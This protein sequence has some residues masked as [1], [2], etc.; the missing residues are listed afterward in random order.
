MQTQTSLRRGPLCLTLINTV[1][2]IWCNAFGDEPPLVP[3]NLGIGFCWVARPGWP[4]TLYEASPCLFYETH[5]RDVNGEIP[6]AQLRT[7]RFVTNDAAAAWNSLGEKS[8]LASHTFSNPILFD[9][10]I[11]L[12]ALV[13]TGTDG[14]EVHLDT[15]GIKGC[16]FN[17]ER[18]N[19]QPIDHARQKVSFYVMVERI[20]VNPP[21]VVA[22][23]VFKVQV[24]ARW[25]YELDCIAHISGRTFIV[26]SEEWTEQELDV[27]QWTE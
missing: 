16:T 10:E 4:Y 2:E 21:Q 17:Y 7:R 20:D 19:N 14:A 18:Y 11:D 27:S 22:T 6:I 3:T 23:Q 13:G 9:E 12:P 8:T 15:P 1:Y 24:E 26:V 25:D 5:V